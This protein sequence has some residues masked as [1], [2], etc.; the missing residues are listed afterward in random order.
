MARLPAFA[1]GK[2]MR[3]RERMGRK[4]EARFRAHERE[5]TNRDKGLHVRTSGAED[6]M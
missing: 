5:G 4:E 3:E 6:A 1:E 2:R